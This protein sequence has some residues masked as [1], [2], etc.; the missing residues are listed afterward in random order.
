LNFIKSYK[1][2]T[3]YNIKQLGNRQHFKFPTCCR[4]GAGGLDCAVFY[5]PANTV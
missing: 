1:K 4:W 3:N 5:V 2:F